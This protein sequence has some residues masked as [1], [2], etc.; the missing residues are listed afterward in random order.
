MNSKGHI[1]F[2]ALTDM[3]LTRRNN[4][5]SY[6]VLS[7]RGTTYVV[8]LADG[9]GGHKRGELASSI[10][11]KYI[12]EC[13]SRDMTANMSVDDIIVLVRG[14]IEKANVRV[15]LKSLDDESNEGMGT[16][17]TV[18]IFQNNHLVVAHV[19]DCRAYLMH[20]GELMHLT[21]DHTL[22]QSLVDRGELT[23]DQAI[24]HPKR[25][26]VTRALGT[27]EYTSPDV[28]VYDIRKGDRVLFSTDGLHDYVEESEIFR[29]LKEADTPKTAATDLVDQANRVGGADNV[30]VVVGFA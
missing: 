11:V 26:V 2:A 22:V 8:I 24:N 18:G 19:G 17:V 27:P 6:M 3:G 15:H 30:T 14:V 28:A 5:D 4:E 21:L 16:T 23:Q 13:L 12:S 9:M 29:I 20:L 7:G 1:Q 25:N 10:A